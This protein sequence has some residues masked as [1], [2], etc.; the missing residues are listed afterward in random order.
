[1]TAGSTASAKTITLSSN[2]TFPITFDKTDV[3]GRCGYY[4]T[5][6][7]K[8][9]KDG[10]LT[11]T[12]CKFSH[13]TNFAIFIDNTEKCFDTIKG[14]VKCKNKTVCQVCEFGTALSDGKCECVTEKKLING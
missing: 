1:M 7:K 10:T 3:T 6:S 13:L 2:G 5:T 4:D 8:W 11:D 12:T 9:I 14:C